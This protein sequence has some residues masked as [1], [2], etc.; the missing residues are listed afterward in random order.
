MR[1]GDRLGQ[2]AA[3]N[4]YWLLCLATGLAGFLL[5]QARILGEVS[6]FGLA[7]VAACAY[8]YTLPAAVGA[9]AGYMLM[10]DPA[11]N[12]GF[13]AAVV[14]LTSIRLLLGQKRWNN[15]PP[16]APPLLTAL[17]GAL[18]GIAAVVTTGT[19]Y[20]WALLFS[21]M[22]LAGAGTYFFLSTLRCGASGFRGLGKLEWVSASVTLGLLAAGLTQLQIGPVSLGRVCIVVGILLVSISAGTGPGTVA[23]VAAGFAMGF[24][25]GDFAEYITAYG[26][27]GLLAGVFAG[28]GRLGAAAAF[29]LTNGFV[30]LLVQ[31]NASLSGL[32]EVFCASVIVMLV[33]GSALRA[34]GTRLI[35]PDN[36]ADTV[37]RVVSATLGGTV[38]AL[39]DI[40]TITKEVSGRLEELAGADNSSVVDRAADKV[41][42]GCTYKAR[43]WQR[44]Y[45]NTTDA[46]S[47]ALASLRRGG[48]VELAVIPDHFQHR[49]I[50]L[51]DLLGVLE[52]E[53]LAYVAGEG[54]RRKVSQVRSVVADQFEGMSLFLEG[55]CRQIGEISSGDPAATAKLREYMLR[56]HMDPVWVVCYSDS[57]SRMW[58]KACLPLF[59]KAR[60]DW[61]ELS[62]TVSQLLDR[63]MDLPQWGEVD[64]R[65]LVTICEK[66]EL[67]VR[68]GSCQMN[69]GGAAVCG[70]SLRTFV[71]NGAVAHLVLSDGMGSG[72]SAAV[73]SAMAASL[74]ARLAQ[75]GVDYDSA[76]RLVNSA[77]LVKSAD[78][79][80]ATLDVTSVDLHTGRAV[81]YKAGAAP[82]I[83]RKGGRAGSVESASIPAGILKGVTF[84]K[85]SLTLHGGDLVMMIS[86]GVCA[87]GVDWVTSEVE[88]YQGDDPDELCRKIAGAAKLRRIDGREDDITVLCAMLDA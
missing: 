14:L 31:Q 64:G 20:D 10:P 2:L 59:K 17:S 66:A 54:A 56:E 12:L 36:D 87:S 41:C 34:T 86:D 51:P 79:S 60:L 75:A 32:L 3:S 76:L 82:T 15:L 50:K 81:F 70:D 4:R 22:M 58:V 73:D 42:R 74:I 80:L 26:L 68:F 11:A 1:L 48:T 23:G 21:R 43:C 29:V 40:C 78:E 13:F 63:E 7:A 37:K 61:E 72:G 38:G 5:A 33:P 9:L 30:L 18:T 19:G 67:A 24:V 39:T 77:L 44:D 47:K 62:L 88:H 45:G 85:S 16:L 53:Y 46:L 52:K 69:C 55:I 71:T 35:S 83:V 25:T 27:G 8:E 84:E 49:C 6:S 28:L 57:G 65:L